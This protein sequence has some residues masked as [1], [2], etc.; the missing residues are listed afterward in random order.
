MLTVNG[1][2]ISIHI[3]DGAGVG[4]DLSLRNAYLVGTALAQFAVEACKLSWTP[5]AGAS[6]DKGGCSN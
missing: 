1:C 6:I 5:T 2:T 3:G 4:I